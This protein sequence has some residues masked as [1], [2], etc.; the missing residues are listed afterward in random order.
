MPM[1]PRLFGTNGVRGV[2]N[3]D[4]DVN[5]ALRL[6]KAIGRFM[7][8]KVALATDTRTSGAMLKHAVIAGLT[9]VGVEVMDLDVLPTPAIQYYVKLHDDVKGGVMITASH[10]PPQFNGIKCIDAD[11]TE[12]PR[13]KEET[14]E[15]YYHSGVP[16]V[17]WDQVGGV[18]KVSGAVERYVDDIVSRVDAESIR[19]AKLKVVLDC[20]NGAAVY[21]M[22]LILD[23][24]GVRAIT[25][26][27]DA[28]GKFPGHPSEPTAENLV[29]LIS[30]TRESKAHL[31]IALDGDADRSVFV[32]DGG[33]F[34][35]GDRSLALVS[36]LML[37]KK[38]GT[39]VTPVSSSSLVEDVV[40]K[41]GGIL[42]YTA[43]GSPIVARKMMDIGA[44]FGGEENGGLI[45]PE[46]QYCR[47]G[48]MTVA[49]MLESIVFFGPL[50]EQLKELPVYHVEKRKI[51][52]S[53]QQKEEIM[54]SLAERCADDRL[55]CT[56][57]L[58][59]LFDDGWVLIRPSGTEPIFRIYSESRDPDRCRER[60]DEFE[61]MLLEFLN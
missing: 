14:I 9:A 55:D 3:D 12:M 43:V 56:D 44:V 25:L 33:E 54:R 19:K 6:G 22:P 51:V 46:H 28:Q 53:N 58:K 1:V 34:V 50:S 52:C 32:A 5:L 29:D 49:K 18:Q 15:E 10:N 23:R 21:T 60:A 20:A 37:Q 11:G 39:V 8:G 31:G 36:K 38:K 4:M 48:G 24:L 41:A 47:D 17:G 13:S 42:V 27:S 59:V 16:C 26:N 40:R 57:G 61:V 30:L 2:V 35:P 7:G 45:F